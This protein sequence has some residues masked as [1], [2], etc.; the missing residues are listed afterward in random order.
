MDQ[1][2]PTDT[3]VYPFST[4]LDPDPGGADAGGYSILLVGLRHRVHLRR[5]TPWPLLYPRQVRALQRDWCRA[6]TE[7]G[8]GLHPYLRTPPGEASAGRAFAPARALCPSAHEALFGYG[9]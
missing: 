1:E 3:G 4:T 8:W 7:L 6:F 9:T 2:S 5:A